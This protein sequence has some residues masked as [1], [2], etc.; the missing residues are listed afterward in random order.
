MLYIDLTLAYA[1][2]RNC[3]FAGAELYFC[4]TVCEESSDVAY[5]FSPD[6]ILFARPLAKEKSPSPT[7]RI[8]DLLS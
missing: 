7:T 6:P 5:N 8:R 3:R 2:L 1:C 4:K